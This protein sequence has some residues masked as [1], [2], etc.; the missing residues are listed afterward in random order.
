MTRA[1]LVPTAL[2]TLLAACVAACASRPPTSSQ[3]VEAR[4]AYGQALASAA[5][6]LA[7][8]PL[9]DAQRALDDAEFVHRESPGSDQEMFRAYIATRRAQLA[10]AAA[11]VAAATRELEAARIAYAAALERHDAQMAAQRDALARQN[12]ELA[13]RSAE[14][15]P[16][17][18]RKNA[19]LAAEREARAKLERER[20][21]ALAKIEKFASIHETTRGTVITLG[22]AL[23]FRSGSAELIPSARAK[24]D[25]IATALLAVDTDQ[26]LLIEGHAD[27]RGPQPLNRELSAAR[28]EAVRAYLVERGVP[29]ERL[30]SLGRGEDQPLASNDTAEGRATNRRVEIVITR[31]QAATGPTA[32]PPP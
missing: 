2:A 31:P 23:L 26:N 22:G 4:R 24:L 3:L 15:V 17:L 28:A 25:Q 7:P 30:V 16:E 13:A 1:R 32:A 27:A 5:P 21:D 6:V 20:D 18:A 29:R 14:L 10:I 11:G 19:Q 8:K 12:Q 9:F